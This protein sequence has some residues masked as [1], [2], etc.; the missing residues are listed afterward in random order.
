MPRIIIIIIIIII[1]SVLCFTVRGHTDVKDK[2]II[3]VIFLF[4]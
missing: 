1:N 3:I 4:S 2:N